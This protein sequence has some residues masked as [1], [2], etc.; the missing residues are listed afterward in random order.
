MRVELA[1]TDEQPGPARG[2]EAVHGRA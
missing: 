1:C 2:R